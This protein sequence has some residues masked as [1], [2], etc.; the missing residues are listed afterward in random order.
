MVKFQMI[1]FILVSLDVHFFFVRLK[2]NFYISLEV[3]GYSQS[4]LYK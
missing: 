3:R 4:V 1:H 2:E